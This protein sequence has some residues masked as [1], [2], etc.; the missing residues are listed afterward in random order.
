VGPEAYK[1]WK[2][3]G[4]EAFLN[5]NTKLGTKV[6]IYLEWEKNRNKLQIK[7]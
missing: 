4:G 6:N 7:K 3:G 5:K 1:I 2:G